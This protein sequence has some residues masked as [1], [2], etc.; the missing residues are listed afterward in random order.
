[1]LRTFVVF[2]GA[3]HV[4]CCRG[5]APSST[6]APLAAQPAQ[7][8]KAAQPD[9][10]AANRAVLSALPFADCRDF[11]DA[12]REFVA[13]VPKERNPQQWVFLKGDAPPAVNPS[14]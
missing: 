4:S 3:R 13:T 12:M 2:V 10:A 5:Q 11:E 9:V 6:S 7:S 14:L 8:P 1:L